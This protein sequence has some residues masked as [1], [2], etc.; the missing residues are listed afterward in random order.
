MSKLKLFEIEGLKDGTRRF[1]TQL[2]IGSDVADLVMGV[3]LIMM[4][5]RYGDN[6]TG[7]YPYDKPY[8]IVSKKSDMNIQP[9]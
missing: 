2:L 4:C 1:Q 3:D 7:F 8:E 5:W 6:G 9:L